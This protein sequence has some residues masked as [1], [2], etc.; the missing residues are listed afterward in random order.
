MFTARNEQ[1]YPDR[2]LSGVLHTCSMLAVAL[3]IGCGDKSVPPATQSAPASAQ[4]VLQEM[5]NTYRDASSYADKA[6]VQLH[7]QRDGQ[8]Y[9]DRAPAA[10]AWQ[11]PNRISVRA[12]EVE[13]V[14]DGNQLR[15]K[16]R[17]RATHDFDGQVV[18]RP[19]SSRLA[20]DQFYKSDGI[21]SL[22]LRQGLVGYPLQLDLLLA[23]QPLAVMMNN[24]EVTHTLL[25]P[26][27]IGDHLCD[28]VRM[29]STDGVFVFWIDHAAHVLRRVEYPVATFAPDVANDTM[30][31][32]A[33]LTVEFAEVAVNTQL[34][35]A[36][37]ALQVSAD[38][39]PV[40]K[41]IPPPRELSS[42]LFGKQVSPFAFRDLSNEVVTRDTLGDTIKI[43]VWFNNHPACK[44]TL[45]QLN[46][47]YAQYRDRAGFRFLAV[48]VEPSSTTD[49]QLA[50]LLQLWQ[51]DV[52][53]VRDLE[54][55]GRDV[56]HIPWAP[57][58][59]VLDGHNTLHIF[60]VGVN[61]ELVTELPQ[62]LTRLAA[63]DDL[64]AEILARFREQRQRYAQQLKQGE[65]D[66]T[67]SR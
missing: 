44:A 64:A 52:P 26:A 34:S 51:V 15:A 24:Q 65:P 54:A 27:K 25:E 42:D 28:R 36:T 31:R 8:T 45:Q 66:A 29:Q 9:E 37:F 10:V 46:R 22:A 7:Y 53:V 49:E 55:Y 5:I 32:D 21:L 3:A 11:S 43:L 60:E 17:D 35:K 62:V 63:G 59:V 38:S 12:Y 4:A 41:F 50:S 40:R 56:F 14:C 47:V 39:K 6:F 1:R 18:T 67:T 16:I 20:L 57:T 30:V 58:L 33:H 13:V 19:V 61:D 2:R 48:C 23:D